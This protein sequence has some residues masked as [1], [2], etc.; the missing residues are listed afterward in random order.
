V[1]LRREWLASAFPTALQRLF[2]IRFTSRCQPFDIKGTMDQIL[3]AAPA[4]FCENPMSLLPAIQSACQPLAGPADQVASKVEA[5]GLL[6]DAYPGVWE[7]RYLSTAINSTSAAKPPPDSTDAAMST[8]YESR[9]M[10][11]SLLLDAYPGAWEPR[12]L[13]TAISNT[14]AAK[15]PPDSSDAAKAIFHQSQ[16][17]LLSLLFKQITTPLQR[18]QQ[19]WACHLLLH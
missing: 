3:Q 1:L 4:G 18:Q 12:Y 14:I 5:A 15:P 2:Q 6:L 16:T 7:P 8:F 9:T 19:G 17:K 10:L 13:S 11:L